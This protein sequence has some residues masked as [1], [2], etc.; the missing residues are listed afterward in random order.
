V[1][2]F[3]ILT[4][5]AEEM[6]QGELRSLADTLGA[7]IKDGVVFLGSAEGEKVSLVCKVAGAA[8]GRVSAAKIVRETAKI[9]GGSGGGRDDIAQAGGK[10]PDKLPEALSAVESLVKMLAN[11]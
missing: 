9:V 5:Q 2:G 10:F 6:T 7:K 4:Y 11:K 3:K 8:L 1:G